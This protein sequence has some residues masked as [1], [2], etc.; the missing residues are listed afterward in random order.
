MR[1][2]SENAHRLTGDPAEYEPLLNR[3]GDARLVLLGEASH[4]T[5]E[6]YRARDEITRRLIRE[7]GFHAVAVEADWPD[8]SRVNTFVRGHGTDQ[9]ADEALGSFTR[10]PRWMWRNTDMIE[11]VSWL[12]KHNAKSEIKVGFYG[13]DLYSLN[14]SIGEVLRYLGKVDPDGARRARDRYACFD[15]YGDDPQAYGHAT[16]LGLA[17]SCENEVLDQLVELQRRAG[18]LAMLDGRVAED[19]FFSATQNA[20]LI[21]NAEQ[22]YRAMFSSR[23]STWNLRD[24]HMAETL[25]QLLA[26]L[27]SR[28]DR[29]KIVVWAHNSHLGDARA[30]AMGAR[31]ELNVGHLVRQKHGSD[32]VLVGFTTHSGS[33]R[34]AG[35]WESPDKLM[36]VKPALPGSFEALFHDA[37]I[38]DFLLVFAESPELGQNLARPRLERAIGVVYRPETERASHYFQARLSHQFD[39]VIHY[40]QSRATIGIGGAEERAPVVGEPEPPETYPHGV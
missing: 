38:P 23:L 24:T 22:Y 20:R 40:N 5:H 32:A 3:I 35:D 12:Q 17:E 27:D 8:A 21:R 19:E 13:L 18:E 1:E 6:F 25:E 28:M 30:T 37:N 15:H 39:A 34:A 36:E 33:V 31:G 2:I 9:N 16:G 10:F 4:G 14:R 29:V 26:H 7:K 11:F